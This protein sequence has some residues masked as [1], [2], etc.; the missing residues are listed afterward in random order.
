[1]FWEPDKTLIHFDVTLVLQNSSMDQDSI[2]QDAEQSWR[3]TV[4][5]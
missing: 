2:A 1:M 5:L 4:L 3:S